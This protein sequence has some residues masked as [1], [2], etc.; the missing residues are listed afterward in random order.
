MPTFQDH[1]L[2]QL[3]VREGK[4]MYQTRQGRETEYLMTQPIQITAKKDLFETGSTDVLY[5][6]DLNESPDGTW[7]GI[8]RKVLA[9]LN[10]LIDRSELQFECIPANL[11]GRYNRI[12]EAIAETNRLYAEHKALLTNKVAELDVQRQQEAEVQAGRTAAVKDQ[13][14]KLNL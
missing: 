1:P 4:L 3:T 2:A 7:L 6:F 12:K 11:E 5:R 8:F 14:T 10:A 13:F 9:P